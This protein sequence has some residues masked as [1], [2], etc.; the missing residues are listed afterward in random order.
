MK[1]NAKEKKHLDVAKNRYRGLLMIQ[2][3]RSAYC[4]IDVGVDYQAMDFRRKKNAT[5]NAVSG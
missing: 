1:N 2:L 3:P 4:S 5:Y